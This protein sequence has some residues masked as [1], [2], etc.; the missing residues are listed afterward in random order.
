MSEELYWNSTGSAFATPAW[1]D[2]HHAVKSR[3]RA[4]LIG[5]LPIQAG[6]CV[7][8]IGCGTGTWAM[9]AADRVGI[10]GRII[11]M[12]ADHEALSLAHARRNAHVLKR[13]ISFEQ[14][15]ME[16]FEAEPSSVD[17]VFLFNILSYLRDPVASIERILP[18]LKPGA[19]IF[20]KDTD[21]QSDFFWP[22][23]LDLYGRIMASVAQAP[24]KRVAGNYDPFFARRILG[25]LNSFG[26]FRVTTLSQ[27][28]SFFSPASPEEREYI[29][30]NARMLAQIAS[31]NGAAEIAGAWFDFF[32]DNHKDCIFNREDF[33]YSMNEFVF[34]AGLV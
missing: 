10:H 24:S 8:D 17:A 20:I 21:L 3:L 30:A 6:D 9:L 7:L 33:I 27:S 26:L 22:D 2:N 34:Q 5:K 1:L 18:F 16:T 19:K 25:I 29:R 12:D 31:E 28:A 14:A 11:G 15:R 32:Q 13:I 23:P 4:E